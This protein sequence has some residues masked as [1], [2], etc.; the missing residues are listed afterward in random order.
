MLGVGRLNLVPDYGPGK[1]I[2]LLCRDF[3]IEYLRV[4]RDECVLH[5]RS[6][7]G[8]LT[9][10]AFAGVGDGWYMYPETPT[11]AP[12]FPGLAQRSNDPDTEGSVCLRA[13]LSR[14]DLLFESSKKA[15]IVGSE[16]LVSAL[17]LDPIQAT[18]PLVSEYADSNL[19]QPQKRQSL[20][21]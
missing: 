10:L 4:S 19:W 9:L 12:N 11:W 14:W 2:G 8:V 15:T 21:H 20:G 5:R 7:G 3:M 16:M 13:N 1:S 18:G 17:V 6:R